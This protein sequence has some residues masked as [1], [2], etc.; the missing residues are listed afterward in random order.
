MYCCMVPVGLLT[1]GLTRLLR[2]CVDIV[3]AVVEYSE[4]KGLIPR[5]RDGT[6]LPYSDN[7]Q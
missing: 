1:G 2:Y 7:V 4:W 6:V 5:R 3:Q